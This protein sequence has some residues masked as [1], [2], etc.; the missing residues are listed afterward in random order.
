MAIGVTA[1]LFVQLGKNAA[2][3]AIFKRLS[4]AVDAN[5]P[6]CDFYHLYKLR[7]EDNSYMVLEQYVDEAALSA[8]QTTDHYL[9]IGAE[10]GPVM[11]AAPEIILMD[12]V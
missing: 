11:A 12:S 3:E 7:S 10:L 4:E 6:G 8:H 2:F 9:K 1:K 5:E